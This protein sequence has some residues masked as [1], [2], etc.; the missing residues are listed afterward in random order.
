MR[1]WAQDGMSPK[2]RPRGIRARLRGGF[3][4]AQIAQCHAQSLSAFFPGGR[5]VTALPPARS[6]EAAVAA[7][8]AGPVRHSD[9]EVGSLG[10][11]GSALMP[12]TGWQRAVLLTVNVLSVPH[13]QPN[14]PEKH[15][16]NH[17]TPPNEPQP[18]SRWSTT[19]TR[20]V[21]CPLSLHT[22]LRPPA[23]GLTR[24]GRHPCRTLLHRHPSRMKPAKGQFHL[25]RALIR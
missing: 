18:Q 24:N 4:P 8:H 19:A 5:G 23:P 3:G 15:R 11:G 6:L 13:Q 1:S 16:P 14:R 2:R 20:K 12:T 25:V 10:E 7:C 9:C 22:E 21:E 17:A